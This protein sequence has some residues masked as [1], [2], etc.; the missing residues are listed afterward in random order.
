MVKTIMRQPCDKR[1]F[2][3][4]TYVVQVLHIYEAAHSQL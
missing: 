1:Y 2:S 4:S 3:M